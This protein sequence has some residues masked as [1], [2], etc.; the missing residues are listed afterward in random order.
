[1]YHDDEIDDL[2]YNK[3]NRKRVFKCIVTFGDETLCTGRYKGF[4][5]KQAA[6]KACTQ[7]FRTLANKDKHVHSKWTNYCNYYKNKQVPTKIIYA[8]HECTRGHKHKKYYYSGERI[9]LANPVFIQINQS[10]GTV[11][12]TH[13][14]MN[15]I[16]VLTDHDTYPEYKLLS[17]Y[18]VKEENEDELEI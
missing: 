4:Q 16:K 2:E 17:N 9:Q 10:G 3:K 14:F 11:N 6:S 18:D 15:N 1:M 7:I 5:P 8:L 13:R 12:L